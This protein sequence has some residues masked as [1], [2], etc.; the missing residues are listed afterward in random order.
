MAYDPTYINPIIENKIEKI[1]NG[2]KYIQILKYHNQYELL[3]NYLR[4]NY[5]N[6]NL[7][8]KITIILHNLSDKIYFLLQE[9]LRTELYKFCQFLK[10]YHK[11]KKF[12][13]D[14]KAYEDEFKF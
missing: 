2:N 13:F 9:S 1:I 7:N 5:D 6:E 14:K 8:M 3:V 12:Y 4:D 10:L 11:I